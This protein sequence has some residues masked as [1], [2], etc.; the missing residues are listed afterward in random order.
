MV[1]KPACVCRRGKRKTAPVEHTDHGDEQ[2]AVATDEQREH[3]KREVY[4]RAQEGE[5]CTDDEHH[6][7]VVVRTGW[8]QEQQE[9]RERR[10]T[11][12]IR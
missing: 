7:R 4:G 12:D 8:E 6:A 3:I 9:V 10:D 11:V 2:E 1:R 5:D